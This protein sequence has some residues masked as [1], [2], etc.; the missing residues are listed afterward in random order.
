MTIWFQIFSIFAESNYAT[1]RN[2]QQ[3][4]QRQDAPIDRIRGFHQR[5]N[6]FGPT[7][8]PGRCDPLT[9]QPWPK[10]CTPILPRSAARNEN[11]DDCLPRITQAPPIGVVNWKQYCSKHPGICGPWPDCCD[12]PC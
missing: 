4:F 11:Q 8:R 1:P 6:A 2:R 9:C 10:C 3:F 7:N 12:G 5:T